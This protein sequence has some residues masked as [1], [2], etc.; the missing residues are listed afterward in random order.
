[1]L[2]RAGLNEH[3]TDQ[4]I[5]HLKSE[6]ASGLVSNN[7]D[8]VAAFVRAIDAKTTNGEQQRARAQA[9]KSVLRDFL[10]SVAANATWQLIQTAFNAATSIEHP[11]PTDIFPEELIVESVGY[12]PSLAI[13]GCQ[14]LLEL[15]LKRR[16][17]LFGRFHHQVAVSLDSLA[18]CLDVKG[19]HKEA[20]VLRERV[21]EVEER[22]A[23]K[24]QL[25]TG[26]AL[27]NLGVNLA[28]RNKLKESILRLEQGAKT[29]IALRGT[30]HL[31]A[32]VAVYDLFTV[33]QRRGRLST[34]LTA[35]QRE[36]IQTAKDNM[37]AVMERKSL[38][39]LLDAGREGIHGLSEAAGLS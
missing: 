39:A 26:V 19:H 1:M 13:G 12:F 9:V 31:G 8:L 6:Y 4:V 38:L 23:G 30:Q 36:A 10:L 34:R 35:E 22:V 15:C 32:S 20:T 11:P 3:E 25:N 16:E 18:M 17:R 37:S 2:T 28:A 29:V 21:V 27:C 33:S 14:D 5:N 24:A 7:D